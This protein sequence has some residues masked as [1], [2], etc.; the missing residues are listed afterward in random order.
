M[1]GLSDSF[2]FVFVSVLSSFYK[3]LFAYLLLSGLA[4]DASTSLCHSIYTF[5][6]FLILKGKDLITALFN[7][8]FY[9]IFC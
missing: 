2:K 9:H 5:P 8:T 6:D 3:S 4:V 7:N 1:R